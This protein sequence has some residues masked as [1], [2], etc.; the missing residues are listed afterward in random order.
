MDWHRQIFYLWGKCYF[1][2]KI[3][4]Q[5]ITIVPIS[6]VARESVK[7]VRKAIREL[8]PDYVAVELCPERTAERKGKGK[9]TK[10]SILAG[11][12]THIQ[13]KYAK[14][15]GNQAGA[16]MRAA[17][18][19]AKKFGAEVLAIDRPISVTLRRMRKALSIKDWLRLLWLVIRGENVPFDL[20]EVPEGAV[21]DELVEE[22]KAEFPNLYKVLITERDAYM[23]R[24][25]DG[26]DNVVVVIGAGHVKGL[27]S[28]LEKVHVFGQGA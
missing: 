8:R 23:A 25:L 27:V 2:V 11:L 16:E 24:M 19:E 26:K 7:N 21:V 4:Q 17:I 14:E 5:V 3:A 13:N 6:H 12:L 28:R 1:W 10:N 20:N 22:L 15:A 18:S 9:V